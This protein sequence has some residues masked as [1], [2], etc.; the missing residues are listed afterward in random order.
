MSVSV[1]DYRIAIPIQQPGIGRWLAIYGKREIDQYWMVKNSVKPGDTALEIGA[2]IG[3]YTILLAKII[4][5]SGWIYAAEPDQ[6]SIPYLHR[7]CRLNNIRIVS[8]IPCAISDRSGIAELSCARRS[9]LSSLTPSRRERPWE[10]VLTQEV[11]V[12]DVDQ[13]ISTVLRKITVI[14][15][16]IEGHETVILRQLLVAAQKPEFQQRLPRTIIFETHSPEYTAAD[17]FASTLKDLLA[18]GYQIKFLSLYG[19]PTNT[20]TIEGCE[21]IATL[22]NPDRT[23]SYNI[24]KDPPPDESIHSILNNDCVG[25]VTLEKDS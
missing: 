11:P 21:N 4:G 5:E 18:L 7:N 1:W 19:P 14:R 22:T 10:Y 23:R 16:D 24:Y 13:I 8:V 25:A 17:K 3:Y 20:P 9:N 6:R 2:N 12:I 15:M